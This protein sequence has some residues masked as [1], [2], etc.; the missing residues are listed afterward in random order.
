MSAFFR[1]G[2]NKEVVVGLE[3]GC[4]KKY[5]FKEEYYEN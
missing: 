3:H 2:R 1:N 4:S 5:I